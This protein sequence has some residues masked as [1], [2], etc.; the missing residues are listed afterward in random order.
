MGGILRVLHFGVDALSSGSLIRA[1]AIAILA[2]RG[3]GKDVF[4]LLPIKRETTGYIC[5]EG[6]NISHS[7][8]LMK[9]IFFPPPPCP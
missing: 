1:Y 6:V 2:G 7:Q 4:T 5:I 3:K 8:C 9:N